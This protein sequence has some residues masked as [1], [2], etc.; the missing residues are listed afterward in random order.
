MLL[1]VYRNSCMDGMRPR[2]ISLTV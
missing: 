1:I 2:E